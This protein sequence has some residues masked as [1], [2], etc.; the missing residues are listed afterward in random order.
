MTLRRLSSVNAQCNSCILASVPY[1]FPW[2]DVKYQWQNFAFGKYKATIKVVYGTKELRSA[3]A[4][5]TF[6]V[7]PWQLLLV[8]ISGA[9]V[10]LV[11]GR[12]SLKRYNRYIIAQSQRQGNASPR[13]KVR[14]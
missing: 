14:K 12:F 10:I 6:W 11:V 8:T 7:I 2:N 9:A 3:N 5:V 13:K 4:K 1:P